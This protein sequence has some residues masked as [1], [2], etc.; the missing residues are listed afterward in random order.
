MASERLLPPEV[1]AKILGVAVKTLANWRAA[2]TGPPYVRVEHS[3]RYRES[4]VA[5]WIAEKRIRPLD[6]GRQHD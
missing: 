1:V 3:I 5:R 4:D 6:G 2:G